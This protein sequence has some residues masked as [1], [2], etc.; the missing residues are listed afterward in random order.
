MR[1]EF[2]ATGGEAQVMQ[3]FRR[4]IKADPDMVGQVEHQSD[5]CVE[6]ILNMMA[7]PAGPFTAT[8]LV[9]TEPPYQFNLTIDESSI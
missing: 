3:Q 2:T 7:L 9:N 8:L 6:R 5:I 4:A 1:K